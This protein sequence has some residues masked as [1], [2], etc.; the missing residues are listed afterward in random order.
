MLG[1][2][3]VGNATLTVFDDGPVLSTDPWIDGTPYFGS[4]THPYEISEANISNII[5]S[6]YIWLSHGHP[7]HIDSKS[8]KY[9]HNAIILIPDHFGDRIFHYF[10]KHFECIKIKSN[11]WFEISKNVRIKSFADWNQDAA[12]VVEI[13]K[14]DCICNM[15]DG[16]LLGWKPTV[17]KLIK[18][19]PNRFLLR[20]MNWGDADMINL[21]DE[22]D[23]FIKPE[24]SKRVPLGPSYEYHMNDMGCNFAI[25][26]STFHRY[27][28]TDSEKMNKFITPIDSHD[29][30]FFNENKTILQAH[31]FWD[32]I[33]GDYTPTNPRKTEIMLAKPEDFGDNYS[34]QLDNNEKLLLKKYFSSFEHLKNFFGC[35]V[36]KVGGEEISIKLSDRDELIYFEA[37]RH[38]LI[39]SIKHEI[40]DDMLIGNFMKTKLINC[41]S[42]YPNFSPYVAKYGDNGLAKS[43]VELKNYFK[44]YKLNSADYWRDLLSIN[45]ENFLRSHISADTIIYKGLKYIKN[46]L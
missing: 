25:P 6:K 12:L 46:K 18:N 3:T 14:K 40:F 20:L 38:S 2:E 29:E 17:K 41:E 9:L 43:Q 28:R 15:N 44:Y 7:D 32:S 30:N 31:G 39:T 24:A 36:F 5:N 42:L 13:Q 23:N 35:I 8:Y 11:T 26:F 27:N 34:D 22:N 19:Y 33:K 4:W 45:T 1:F 16:N 10:D 37:P 21:Y